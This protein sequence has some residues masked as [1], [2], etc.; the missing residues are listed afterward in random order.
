MLTGKHPY[1]EK[2]E[3]AA[4][5]TSF[6]R[7]T[8]TPAYEHNPLVPVWLDGALKKALQLDPRRRYDALS[9]WIGDMKTPNPRLMSDRALPL[10][11]RDP[12]LLWQGI[13]AVLLVA[14]VLS[15]VL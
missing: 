11:E 12:V 4:S 5:P 14:L 7:L 9:E 10:A 3:T 6:A 1:G 8:Y 13:S 15:W 2:Y